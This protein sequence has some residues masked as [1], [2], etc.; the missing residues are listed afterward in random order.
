MITFIVLTKCY[1]LHATIEHARE[2]SLAELF[3]STL[4]STVHHSRLK[5]NTLFAPLLAQEKRNQSAE[6]THLMTLKLINQTKR[7]GGN[8][9]KLIKGAAK[10]MSSFSAH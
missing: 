8:T 7:R 10:S 5:D 1:P 9:I 4:T 6:T 3:I 2:Y